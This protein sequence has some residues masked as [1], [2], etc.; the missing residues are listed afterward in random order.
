[1]KRWGEKKESREHRRDGEASAE[2]EQR[3]R[4]MRRVLADDRVREEKREGGVNESVTR[5]R[6]KGHWA[7]GGIRASTLDHRDWVVTRPVV[8]GPGWS[9]DRGGHETMAEWRAAA[10]GG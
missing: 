2:E 6:G 3:R 5:M 7:H 8:T 1:M 10:A 9:R 4:A